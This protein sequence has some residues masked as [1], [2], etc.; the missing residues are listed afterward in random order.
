MSKNSTV[1]I[2]PT[3]NEAESL[4]VLVPE[5]R[6]YT[7]AEI[8]IVD[9]SSDNTTEVADSLGCIV[10][11]GTGG[12]L[13]SAV[14]QGFRNT[15]QGTKKIIVMDADGQHPP[16]LLPHMILALDHN[17]MV[18]A[19]RLNKH[20]YGSRLRE[21]I[22]SWANLTAWVIAPQVKDRM[23]GY[24]GFRPD[25]LNNGTLEKLN[26]LGFKIMLEVLV[27]GHPETLEQIPY[28][29]RPRILGISKLKKAQLQRQFTLQILSLL[30]YRLTRR[31]TRRLKT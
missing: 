7:R 17:D 29:I 21:V 2:L 24:F 14:I 28:V 3:L 15:P 4:K 22:S 23:S 1:I 13:A 10:F 20:F 19:S 27:K 11:R 5:I 31:L 8:L 18:V 25:I 16:E 30:L 6:N 12:T 9:D 26:G